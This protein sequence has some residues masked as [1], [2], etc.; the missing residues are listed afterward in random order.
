M[1]HE[2]KIYYVEF[3]ASDLAATK[4]FFEKSFGWT[5]TDYGPDYTSFADGR[6]AGGFFRSD[7]CAS[8]EAGSPLVVLQD[9]KIED[10][11][12]RVTGNGGRITKPIFPYPG[13]RRFHFTEPSGNELSVCA[14]DAS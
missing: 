9:Q 3:H 5:F 14:E 13:G 10:C 1:K 11:L 8:F 2:N 6:I 7:R 12:A 4:A